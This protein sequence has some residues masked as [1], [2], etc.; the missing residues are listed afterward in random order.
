MY[1]KRHA[2]DYS[3][4]LCQ[5]SK[6]KREREKQP[7]YPLKR[8]IKKIWIN[9]LKHLYKLEYATAKKT[10]P[11]KIMLSKKAKGLINII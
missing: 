4:K 3:E 10:N 9:K 11:I 2:L 5:Y 8:W 1:I 6:K 7:P